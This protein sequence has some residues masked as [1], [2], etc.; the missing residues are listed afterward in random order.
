MTTSSPA[1]HAGSVDACTIPAPSAAMT[2]GGVTRWAPWAIQRSR[3]LI[4]AV[5][6][7]T[8]TMPGPGSVL[9]R[10]LIRTP[11]G[12]IGSS[13]TAALPWLK[14]RA[15]GPEAGVICET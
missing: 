2:L 12:P 4:E 5:R 3:W 8:A 6:I 11:A 10:S 15:C 1:V 13:Y 7:E 9:G 14:M